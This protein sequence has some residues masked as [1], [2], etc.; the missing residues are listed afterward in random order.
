MHTPSF[1]KIHWILLKLSSGNENTDVLLAYKSVKNNENPLKFTQVIVRKQKYGYILKT[2][3]ILMQTH[4]FPILK[5]EVTFDSVQKLVPK[6][7]WGSC[8][9]LVWKVPEENFWDRARKQLWIILG[10]G[11]KWSFGI[12]PKYNLRNFD[13]W[14]FWD[15]AQKLGKHNIKYIPYQKLKQ[16]LF[17]IDPKT[18]TFNRKVFQ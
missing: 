8:P 14:C 12:V 17:G 1:V 2:Q 7:K 9:K 16:L 10:I 15:R 11:P 13:K 4:N 5:D 3:C 18:W 6:L